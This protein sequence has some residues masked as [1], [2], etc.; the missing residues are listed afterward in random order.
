M[1]SGNSIVAAVG[2][3]ARGAAVGVAGVA[4]WPAGCGA[5]AGRGC[6]LAHDRNGSGAAGADRLDHR[7]DVVPRDPTAAAGPDD[8]LGVERVLPQQP[9][10]RRCHPRVGIALRRG[11]RGG[12]GGRAGRR[13]CLALRLIRPGRTVRRHRSRVLS[14]SA[15]ERPEAL[16]SAPRPARLS[17]RRLGLRPRPP[18]GRRCRSAGTVR[19]RTL[20]G[21]LDDGDLGVVR[22]RRAFLGQ[23]LLEDALVRRRHLR[24]DLVG[25]D[26][27][28][29]LVLVDMVAGLLEPLAD[30]PLGDA[31]A[32][33]GHRHLRHVR[34]SFAG[35]RLATGLVSP[36]RPIPVECP[37]R[38]L[39]AG[40]RL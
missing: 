23:D 11:W 28:Q 21:G 29:R 36:I 35:R 8:L 33:L 39:R 27:E 38:H 3:P 40:T 24:V 22:D 31:L 26:L 13:R 14:A 12:G 19:G 10:H 16:P 18:S 34:C 4:G 17:L 6:S 30:R 25:D 9:T 15:G 1:P 5:G 32:E 37:E 20:V 7:E 2:R